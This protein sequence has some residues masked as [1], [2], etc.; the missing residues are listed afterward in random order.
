MARD[1]N[2]ATLTARAA[3]ASA[4]TTTVYVP[5]GSRPLLF[6]G[7]NWLY[8]SSEANTD[9]TFDWAIAY[10]TDGTTFT[11]L[12]ANGNANG[13]LD[14]SA[15]LVQNVNK[16]DAASGGGAAIAVTPTQARIPANAVVRFTL[17]TAGTGTI[18]AVQLTADCIYV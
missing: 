18:P 16:G 3:A 5:T 8:E 14:S 13:L 9:N 11:T 1:N 4:G 7:F 6:N 17:V 10:A 15:V 2:I 12:Y